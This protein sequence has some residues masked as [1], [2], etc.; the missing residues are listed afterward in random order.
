MSKRNRAK[1][2]GPAVRAVSSFKELYEAASE[3]DNKTLTNITEELGS[4]I[5]ELITQQ[6]VREERTN[7]L[8]AQISYLDKR[9]NEHGSAINKLT[10]ANVDNKQAILGTNERVG[11]VKQAA[12]ANLKELEQRLN[13]KI[14]EVQREKASEAW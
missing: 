1:Q 4:A 6:S 14:N 13:G 3:L 7:K 8:V 9:L 5:K 12:M 2:N 10:E 11:L